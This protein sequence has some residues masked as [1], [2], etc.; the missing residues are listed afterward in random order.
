M[1]KNH[2]IGIVDYGAGNLKSVELALAHLGYS[3]LTSGEAS[4]LASCDKLII[5]GDGHAGSTMEVLNKSGLSDF[6][7]SYY[8]SGRWILGICIGC[9]IVL[10]GSDEAEVAC[11]GLIPGRCHKLPGGPGLKVPHMGWNVCVPKNEHFAFKGV[12]K[13]ASFYFVHSYYTKPVSSDDVIGISD[14]GIDFASAIGRDNLLAF[15]FHPEKSGPW[16]LKLLDNFLGA[17]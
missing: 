1:A 6:I 3:W 14:H 12:P 7:K 9:Q 15:Q 2:T 8:Q 13:E 16:G 17:Q 4:K 11:L 5:P 10:D